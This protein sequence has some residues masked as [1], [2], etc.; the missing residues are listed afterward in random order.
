LSLKYLIFVKLNL[1][2]MKI[3]Q[4]DL[5]YFYECVNEWMRSFIIFRKIYI[6]NGNPSCVF[7]QNISNVEPFYKKMLHYINYLRIIRTFK[8]MREKVYDEAIMSHY[9]SVFILWLPFLHLF[10][11]RFKSFK[12]KINLTNI[13]L[14]NVYILVF[15]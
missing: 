15:I 13:K 6:L 1:L 9:K 10:F 2:F 3:S 7:L 12:S 8:L 4:C 11:L 14:L 5:F